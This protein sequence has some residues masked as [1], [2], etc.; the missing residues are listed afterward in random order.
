MINT[1][2]ITGKYAV[3]YVDGRGNVHTDRVGNRTAA[4]SRAAELKAAHANW[5]VRVVAPNLLDPMVI[6]G[7]LEACMTVADDD[8]EQAGDYLGTDYSMTVEYDGTMTLSLGNGQTAF[9]RIDVE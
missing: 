1:T 7:Y 5:T 8:Q 3:R 6:A 2:A 9:I 4:E